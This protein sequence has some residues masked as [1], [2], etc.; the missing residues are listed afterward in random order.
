[1]AKSMSF[2][3]TAAAAAKMGL[4]GFITVAFGL[5]LASCAGSAAIKSAPSIDAV[6]GLKNKLT[7]LKSNAQSGS[8]YVIALDADDRISCGLF[9]K[10]NLSYKDKNNITITIRGVGENRTIYQNSPGDQMFDV[11]SGVTLVLDNNITLRGSRESDSTLGLHNRLIGVSS[12]GT[13]VM[14]DGAAIVGNVNNTGSGG[15]VGVSAGGAFIMNGG[16]I[17]GNMSILGKTAIKNAIDA[18]IIGKAGA[19]ALLGAASDNLPKHTMLS[20]GLGNASE[21][22]AKSD[23]HPRYPACLGGGV[24]VSGASSFFGK[25]TPAGV[26]VKTGGTVTGYDSDPENGN[27]AH[28]CDVQ[29]DLDD[30]GNVRGVTAQY[31]LSVGGGHAVYFGGNDSKSINTTLGPESCFEFRDGIYNETRC[32][33]PKQAESVA[34][35]EPSWGEALADSYPD[36]ALSAAEAQP[37]E[38]GAALQEAAPAPPVQSP[39]EAEQARYEQPIQAAPRRDPVI[40]VAPE[41]AQQAVVSGV[42]QIA[43]YVFGAEDPALNKAMVTRLMAT[44][45][46]SGRYQPAV[47]YKEFFTA[48]NDRKDSAVYMSAERLGKLG[49][50]FGAEYVCVTEIFKAFGEYQAVSHILETESSTVVAAGAGDIPLKTLNDLTAVSEQIVDAMFRRGKRYSLSDAAPASSA[51]SRIIYADGAFTDERD[52]KT[53]RTIKIG[54]D[55]AWMADNLN[56]ATQGGSWCYG[57]VESNCNQY[58]RLYD[59]KTA[60]A[61]CP[62]GWRLPSN[63]EWETLIGAAGGQSA[64]VRLK[65]KNGWSDGGNGTNDYGFAALPGG[66]RRYDDGASENIGTD[67]HWWTATPS[68]SN[69]AYTRNMSHHLNNVYANYYDHTGNGVS[70]R[71]VQ[72]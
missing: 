68:G 53:Y 26:F 31:S 19:A 58:G 69:F 17:S 47:N 16:V 25:S 4:F 33:A 65:A 2:Y 7:W 29:L 30:A 20:K 67:G 56:Y 40:P 8:E 11:G 38:F 57:G 50:A 59:W 44:F 63:Q 42:P 27:S 46:G 12:G 39:P 5:L 52:G 49:K 62:D 55:K 36:T 10:G 60:N 37:A 35:A 61:V 34:A 64:A 24:Y 51:S 72:K 41:P 32:P 6:S 70:V 3:D 14:N 13:L 23:L 71:C 22:V 1:M 18:A 45:S 21:S 66:H 28:D 9:S 43:A 54:G 48:A 15:A